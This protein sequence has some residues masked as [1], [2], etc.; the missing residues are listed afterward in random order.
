MPD[1]YLVN[2]LVQLDGLPNN[3]PAEIAKATHCW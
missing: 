3:E 1:Y 2:K